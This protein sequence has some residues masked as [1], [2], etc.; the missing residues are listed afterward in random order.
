MKLAEIDFDGRRKVIP[1]DS[2]EE[3]EIDT[4][5]SA[6]GEHVNIELLTGNNLKPGESNT[7]IYHSGNNETSVKNVFIGGDAMRGP[8]TVV[9]AIADGKKAAEAIIGREKITAEKYPWEEFEIERELLQKNISIRK[10]NLEK[11]RTDNL[12]LETERCLNCNYVCNKCVDVCPN[13]ANIIIKTGNET[14]KNVN[15]ILHLDDLC[16]ECG[17]C[18]TF[19]PYHGSPYKDKITLFGSSKEFESSNN[20][21]FYIKD[22]VAYW[23]F[24]KVMDM[25]KIDKIELNEI[26]LRENSPQDYRKSIEMFKIII[27]DYSFLL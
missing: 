21:G 7:T 24:N 13:R 2:Y 9:E 14:F 23:R 1:T 4:V 27:K 17:N 12:A 20:N 18:E 5:I 6:I 26:G 8:S 10:G 22:D 3:F 16:N 19:C 15:Q 11:S 25:I